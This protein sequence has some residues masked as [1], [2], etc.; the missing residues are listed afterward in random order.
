MG[1]V[2]HAY[3][4][5]RAAPPFKFLTSATEILE[6]VTKGRRYNVVE[7]MSLPDCKTMWKMTMWKTTM[8]RWCA[9]RVFPQRGIRV[10]STCL[11]WLEAQNDC[12][13]VRLQLVHRLQQ[14]AMMKQSTTLTQGCVTGCFCW[15][16]QLYD[17]DVVI[18][19]LTSS[20]ILNFLMNKL[21]Y[22]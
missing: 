13:H 19:R 5:D 18:A 15:L 14:N 12:D 4:I 8:H 21:N 10:L 17:T 6:R 3:L 7:A 2:S 16:M 20:W 1:V 22:S 9:S 11:P